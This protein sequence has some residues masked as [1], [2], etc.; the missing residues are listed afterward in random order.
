VRGLRGPP[1]C[2]FPSSSP[3]KRRRRA[4]VLQ[5]SRFQK[6]LLLYIESANISFEEELVSRQE[7][8]ERRIAIITRTMQQRL[9]EK[10]SRVLSGMAS[11]PATVKTMDNALAKKVFDLA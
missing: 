2:F 3:K 8:I 7:I 10:L 5:L 1:K 11:L 9:G 4:A 6:P